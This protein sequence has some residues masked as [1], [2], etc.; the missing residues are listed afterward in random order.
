MEDSNVI[1]L[2][3]FIERKYGRT[4]YVIQCGECGHSMRVSLINNYHKL[5][6]LPCPRCD[7]KGEIYFPQDSD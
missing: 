5:E 1:D 7:L 2:E 4:E 6:D 3:K